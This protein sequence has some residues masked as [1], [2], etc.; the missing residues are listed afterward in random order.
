[1]PQAPQNTKDA[2]CYETDNTSSERLKLRIV[3]VLDV[4]LSKYNVCMC[5]CY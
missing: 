3:L 4:Y 5:V 2:Y 1:M